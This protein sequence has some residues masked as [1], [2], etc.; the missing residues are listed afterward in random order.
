MATTKDKTLSEQLQERAFK[1]LISY[2]VFRWESA[3]TLAATLILIAFV[4]DPFAGFL[5]FWRWWFWL[6]LGI[7]AESLIVITSI[8]DPRVRE[9]VV[10]QMFRQRFNP[11]QIATPEYRDKLVKALEYREQMELLLRHTRDNVLRSHLEATASDVSEWL[12]NMFSLAQRLDYYQNSQVLHRDSSLIPDEIKALEQRLTS[13]A[14]PEVRKQLQQTVDNKRAQLKHLEQLDD[15]MERAEL[16]LD[17]TLTAMGTMYA[18]M[19]LIGA[20][21]IDSGRAQRLR[22]DIADEVSSLHDLVQA[23]DEVYQASGA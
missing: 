18:Q 10:G 15:T 9:Q 4:P 12:G 16:Q 8:N 2:A 5:P 21:D 11:Q 14:N 6:V 23:M 20:K 22:K 13:E 3:V 7:L 1:A 17:D 19:Q